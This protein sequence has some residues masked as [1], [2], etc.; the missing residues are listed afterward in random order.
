ME[1]WAGVEGTGVPCGVG[2]ASPAGSLEVTAA[3][4]EMGLEGVVLQWGR[5]GW[6]LA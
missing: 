3:L 2:V 5:A 6:G 1:A 4:W